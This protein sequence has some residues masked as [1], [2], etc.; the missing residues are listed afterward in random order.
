MSEDRLNNEHVDDATLAAF[1]DNRLIGKKR[2]AVIQHLL[3]CDRCRELGM[4]VSAIVQ[5]DSKPHN[6]H[7]WLKYA[8]P[9]GV[10]ASLML[11]L[12]TEEMGK[13]TQKT[14]TAQI[15][16]KQG[17][18]KTRGER[19]ATTEEIIHPSSLGGS[20]SDLLQK[21]SEL[22]PTAAGDMNATEDINKMADSNQ[23]VQ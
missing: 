8:V 20:D 14:C 18:M 12:F 7:S 5:H 6:I 16:T 22:E 1:I 13:L 23:S 4:E 10:A 15:E 11:I 19:V 9:V 2:E 3:S 21:L 17:A